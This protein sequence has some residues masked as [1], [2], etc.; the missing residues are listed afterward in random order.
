MLSD[1][2]KKASQRKP[3]NIREMR[4]FQDT[5]QQAED[6]GDAP[7]GWD[8][9]R[10]APRLLPLTAGEEKLKGSPEDLELRTLS[11]RPQDRAPERRELQQVHQDRV[12]RGPSSVRHR[13]AQCA[14]VRQAAW[15]SR[16]AGNEACSQQID[17]KEKTR[18]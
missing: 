18:S 9:N 13:G 3:D 8:T 5:G 17:R 16:R 15:H 2:N 11:E 14:R 7:R 10:W 1:H 12:S 6:A 4:I